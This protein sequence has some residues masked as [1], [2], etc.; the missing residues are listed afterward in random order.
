MEKSRSTVEESE[1]TAELCRAN[2][3]HRDIRATFEE[4][5]TQCG[6]CFESLSVDKKCYQRAIP[7]RVAACETLLVLMRHISNAETRKEII[8]FLNEGVL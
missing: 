5:N 6:N 2:D 3:D 4:R 7:C 1:N 8:D